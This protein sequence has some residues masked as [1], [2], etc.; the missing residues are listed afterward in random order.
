MIR[1]FVLVEGPTE[2]S[3]VNKVL[4]PALWVRQ[5]HPTP[6]LLHGR[7]NYERVSREVLIIL[8]QDQSAYCTTMID[9]YGLGRG[10]PGTS[11]SS[12]A[13]GLT[14]VRQIEAT[15]KQDICAKVPSLRPDV[16]FVPYLQLHE[17][18]ALLFSHPETLAAAVHKPLLARPFRAIRDAV[19][20]PEEIDDGP[21]TAP[22]KRI[23]AVHPSYSKVIEGVQ[24]AASIGIQRICRECPHFREWIET[25]EGLGRC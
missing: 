19:A 6:I 12:N 16:R 7:T 13:P 2:E 9:F 18:E 8:K 10:F 20:S 4:A 15:F 11:A 3:F 5:V 25:L 21:T 1:L 17:Y 14:K 23:L 22:S 24:A